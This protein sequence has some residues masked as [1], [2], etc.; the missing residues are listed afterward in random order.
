MATS[1]TLLCGYTYDAL[2]RLTGHAP[3][4]QEGTQ[5]FY[6]S[7][8]LATELQGQTSRTV[9]QHGS[10]LLALQQRQGDE[11]NSQLLATDQ[12]RSVLHTLDEA[13]HLPKVYTPYGHRRA[14]SGLSSLLGFNGERRDPV[15]GHY[16]LGNG[17]RAFNPV[18]MRFNSPD[19]LS[20]FGRGGL[21][22]YAYCLGDPI[23]RSDPTGRE[24]WQTWMLAGLS[25]L[26]LVSGGVGLLSAGISIAGMK[27]T[28]VAASAL[29]SKRAVYSGT[30]GAALGFISA[31][32]GATRSIMNTTDP[33][34]SAQ[35]PLLIA[36]AVLSVLSFAATGVSVAYRFRAHRLNKAGAMDVVNSRPKPGS[37][38]L[39]MDGASQR[40]DSSQLPGS[41]K[42][43]AP[44][45]SPLPQTPTPSAPPQTPGG[46]SQPHWMTPD[47]VAALEEL[48][49]VG[50]AFRFGSSRRNS[51]RGIRQT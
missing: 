20:P 19:R 49:G 11:L 39:S 37:L 14:E 36:M 8:H 26:S 44:P 32:V 50:P 46:A 6:N 34:N 29:A 16:L 22:P 21:N 5:R 40:T 45:Q 38:N 27:T 18:L 42:P 31:G 41:L 17:Y 47:I 15:T 30:V 9:F 2:D 3:S 28:S 7:E 35:D 13:Q 33:D 24:A 43:T 10:Q 23:N 1:Q 4:A 12:Q 51:I 25:L 48:G